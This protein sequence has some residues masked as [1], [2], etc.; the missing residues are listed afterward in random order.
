M[1][2]AWYVALLGVIVY[3]PMM[4]LAWLLG[5][6]KARRALRKA[7]AVGNQSA[8]ISGGSSPHGPRGD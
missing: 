4:S 6:M 2:R 3:V 5:R 1:L 7:K 8:T